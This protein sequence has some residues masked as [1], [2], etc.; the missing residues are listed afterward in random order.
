MTV[1]QEILTDEKWERT[2]FVMKAAENKIALIVL[3][4]Q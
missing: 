2:W 3:Y 1:Y 4:N